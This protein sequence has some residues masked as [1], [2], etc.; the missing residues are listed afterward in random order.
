[1]FSTCV[2]S[3]RNPSRAKGAPPKKVRGRRRQQLPRN[4]HLCRLAAHFSILIVITCFA[5]NPVGPHENQSAR[6]PHR[7][8]GDQPW[9]HHTNGGKLIPASQVALSGNLFSLGMRALSVGPSNIDLRP[10]RLNNVHMKGDTGNIRSSRYQ[11][12]CISMLIYSKERSAHDVHA[13]DKPSAITMIRR[14][15]K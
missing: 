5:R 6:N 9:Y 14:L 13:Y 3:T 12:G 4:R 11:S 1:M 7:N 10:T 2:G 8:T 15:L